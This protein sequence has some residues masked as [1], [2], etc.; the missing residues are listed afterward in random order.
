MAESGGRPTWL[1]DGMDPHTSFLLEIRVVG[2]N[3]QLHWYSDSKVVDSNTMNFKDLL[4][5]FLETYRCRYGEVPKLFYFCRET[6]SNIEILSDNDVVEMFAKSS[7]TKICM[8]TLAY[9]YPD[10]K[11]PAIP[12]WDSPTE[13]VD[14]PLT[15]R[16]TA[17]RPCEEPDDSYLVNPEPKNEHV[18]VDEDEIFAEVGPKVT[19]KDADLDDDYFPS[20]DS[21]S[22][23]DHDGCNDEESEDDEMVEDKVPPKF[24]DITWDKD[25]PPM[26]VGTIYPNMHDF[27][28]AL[29]SHSIK[30]EFEYLI[31]KSDPGRCRVSCGARF[32]GCK[33]RL[34]VSNMGDHVTVKVIALTCFQLFIFQRSY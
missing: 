14:I 8:L 22:D 13:T 5:E 11:V 20:T 17:P 4:D 27:R 29:S 25:D 34:H 30:H 28:L 23:T 31:E 33:W 15:P 12:L 7:A 16:M 6:M 2:T 9:H 26:T 1:P 24:E 10:E 21:E 32:E 18:G 19:T 3:D